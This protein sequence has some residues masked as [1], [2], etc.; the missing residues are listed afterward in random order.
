MRTEP[1]QVK[2]EEIDKWQD[3]EDE[4]RF[5]LFC[6]EEEDAYRERMKGI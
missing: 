6:C 5:E 4:E 1:I 3:N 2:T